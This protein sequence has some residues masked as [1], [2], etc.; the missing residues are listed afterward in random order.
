VGELTDPLV[1]AATQ[2][3]YEADDHDYSDYEQAI[4]LKREK[5]YLENDYPRYE[6]MARAAAV[7]VLRALVGKH[8]P[9]DDVD[10]HYATEGL[11]QDACDALAELERGGAA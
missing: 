10:Y 2:A 8:F 9:D 5:P 6:A 11:A 3:L 1:Q 4:R 7:A